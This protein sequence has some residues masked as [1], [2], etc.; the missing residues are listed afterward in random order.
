[1]IPD[2]FPAERFGKGSGYARLPCGTCVKI[3]LV[4]T[5]ASVSFLSCRKNVCKIV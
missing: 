1:M 5:E 2:P 3:N 4:I